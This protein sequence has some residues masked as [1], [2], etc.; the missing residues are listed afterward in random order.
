MKIVSD[1]IPRP[2]KAWH[3]LPRSA[4]LTVQAPEDRNQLR[5]ALYRGQYYDMHDTSTQVVQTPPD[6]WKYRFR[7]RMGMSLLFQVIGDK[8]VCGVLYS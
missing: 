3:D 2:M 1:K 5:Y 6:G 4:Q 8:V 7:E